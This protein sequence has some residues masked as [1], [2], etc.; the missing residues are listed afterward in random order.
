MPAIPTTTA[1]SGI[2]A[3]FVTPG[4][5]S[6]Y[7]RPSRSA[8]ARETPSICASSSGVDTERRPGDPRDELDRAVVVGRAEPARDEADVG[9]VAPLASAAS[10]S[11]GSSP[12]ITMRSGTSP[13][14]S[15]SRA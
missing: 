10:S 11:T 5:K 6:A 2:V 12:T 14:A 9:A 1:P 3:C 4:A 13:S 8:T 7:G 15:A